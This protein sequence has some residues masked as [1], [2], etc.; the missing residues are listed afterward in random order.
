MNVTKTK[1]MLI[2]RNS[3]GKTIKVNV[4]GTTLEQV[5]QFKYLGT[6]ITVDVKN[7][8]RDQKQNQPS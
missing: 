8:T 6:Q 1:T 4:N 7:E 2:S 5:D 3:R